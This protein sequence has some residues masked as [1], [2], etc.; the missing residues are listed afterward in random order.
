MIGTLIL[1][2]GGMARELLAAAREIVGELP[3]FEAV[4]LGWADDAEAAAAQVEHALARL[5]TG[6]G[7]IILADTFGGTPCNVA[8]RFQEPGRV[9]VV[10][11]VNLPMVVR[12]ACHGNRQRMELAEMA[13]WLQDKGR[14]AIC[15]GSEMVDVEGGVVRRKVA[16][17]AGDGG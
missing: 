3:Q 1:S 11:G 2:H 10:S 5:D 6:Q 17:G 15:V 12:L 7:V 4:S 16:V 14:Q 13:H 8:L 9:E